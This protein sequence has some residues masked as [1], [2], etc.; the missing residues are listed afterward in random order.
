MRGIHRFF[1]L[2]GLVFIAGLLA[3]TCTPPIQAQHGNSGACSKVFATHIYEEVSGGSGVVKTITP[4]IINSAGLQKTYRAYITFSGQGI[5]FVC[6]G[7]TPT[8]SLGI[9][10]PVGSSIEV[11]GYDDIINF[12]FINDDDTGTAI[13]H[14]SLQYEKDM[15]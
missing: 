10:V 11:L 3:H 1:I 8:T 4:G 2:I 14:I 5:R 15:Q 9:P 12:K 13:A 7:S 6:D